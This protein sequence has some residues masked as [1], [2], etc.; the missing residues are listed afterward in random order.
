MTLT[1]Y[2]D[3]LKEEE[4]FA[5]KINYQQLVKL[6]AI[7]PAFHRDNFTDIKYHKLDFEFFQFTII[8]QL[9]KF[10]FQLTKLQ[11]N[12]TKQIEITYQESKGDRNLPDKPKPL[13]NILAQ[14]NQK[15][16]EGILK[17]RQQILSFDE[18]IQEITSTGRIKYGKGKSKLCA[19]ICF[20][21]HSQETVLFLWLP[22]PTM[23]IRTKSVGTVRIGRMRI[24]T[25]WGKIS[26]ISH[27]PKG[28]LIRKRGGF[29]SF[30]TY[31]HYYNLEAEN[32][33]KTSDSLER[34]VAFALEKW[35]Q[36]L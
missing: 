22:I 1:R 29:F 35:V 23:R 5:D 18:R 32:S 26:Y 2:Y 11:N 17:I 31:K 3:E 33:L 27:I 10:Y 21:K 12:T 14:C 36:R 20:L 13:L 25:D 16:R 34:I 30:H 28:T 7:A 19:E 6:V 15:E 8:S 4:P 24:E 9:D